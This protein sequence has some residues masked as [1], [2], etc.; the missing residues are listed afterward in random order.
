MQSQVV[1]LVFDS[2]TVGRQAEGKWKAAKAIEE[3][4]LIRSIMRLCESRFGVDIQHEFC[5]SHRGEPGNEL[6]DQLAHSAALGYPLQVWAPFF[7]EVHQSRFVQAM[8][9]A[10]ILFSPLPGVQVGSDRLTFPA[11]PT[12]A[13]TMKVMPLIGENA[14]RATMHV[15][16]CLQIATCNVLT[17]QTGV[18]TDEMR[19]AGVVGPARQE[20]I[21]ATL[22]EHAISVFALQETRLRTVRRTSDHR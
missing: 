19:H 4:H 5:P 1:K 20:W 10:W 11:K 15:Q 6:A 16:V 2:L 14:S 12:T 13:P 17:L 22:D 18:R 21:L 8:E 7:E 3:C 9:W